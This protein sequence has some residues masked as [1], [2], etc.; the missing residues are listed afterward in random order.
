MRIAFVLGSTP[1]RHQD[2]DDLQAAVRAKGDWLGDE[3][4]AV[5]ALGHDVSVHL[6]YRKEGDVRH[7]GVEWFFRRP[8]LTHRRLQKGKELAPTLFRSLDAWK[9]DLVHFQIISHAVNYALFTRWALKRG[10]PIV[11]QQH[12][13]P[14]SPFFWNNWPLGWAARRSRAVIFLTRYHQD[15]Y[16]RKFRIPRERT[17]VIPVGYNEYFGPR[18]REECRRKTGL[19]GDP[20]IIWAAILN[21]RKDPMT[22]L[23]AFRG[24][25]ARFPGARL[26]MAGNGPMEDEIR[27]HVA[28]DAVLS[29]SVKLLGYVNNRDLPDYY[30]AA[31]IYAMASHWEGFAISSMEAMACGAVPVL[32][33]IPCFTEQTDGGR[34]GLLF[35]PG[36]ERELEECLI[37]AIGNTEW[38]EGVRRALPEHISQYTWRAS[39]EGLEKLYRSVLERGER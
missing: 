30:N 27:A 12:G 9:P 1:P 34:L 39:A 2:E 25:S 31:D 10:V 13:Y 8:L 28:G 35:E 5:A 23:K 29:R 19:A 11:G 16:C 22:L 33:R 4:A 26:Y 36:D 3:A 17:H 6:M 24:A 20:V 7:G 32:T 21:F 38:R 18:D 14:I 37:Q 15:L